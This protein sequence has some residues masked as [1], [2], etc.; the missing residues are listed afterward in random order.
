MTVG[1]IK[2]W[3]NNELDNPFAWQRVVM[4]LLP[5]FRSEGYFFHTITDEDTLNEYLLNLID[6][7]VRKFYSVKLPRMSY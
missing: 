6:N 5:S 2:D 7:T 3:L 4:H 1:D